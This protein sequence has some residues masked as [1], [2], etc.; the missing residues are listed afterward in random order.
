M[1]RDLR[2]LGSI[3]LGNLLIAF[4]VSAF[5]IPFSIMQGGTVGM[6]FTIKYLLPFDIRLS[7]V[8]MVINWTLFMVGFLFLGWKFSVASLASTILF[9]MMLRFF[10]DH[11]VSHLFVSEELTIVAVCCGL[12]IGCGI[13]MII[14]AGGSSGGIDIIA[15]ILSRKKGIPVGTSLMVFD[16]FII[17]MQVLIRG[18]EGILVSIVVIAVTSFSVNYF[19]ILGKK[20]VEILIISPE[21]EKI[22]KALLEVVDCGLTLLDVETGYLAL[23]QKAILSVVYASRYKEVRDLALKY[24]EKAFIVVN[25]VREVRGRGYTFSRYPEN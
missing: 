8:N 5:V 24:D 9:P 23:G 12:L 20:K 11:S 19:T 15:C 7:V 4:A 18:M 25:N 2:M 17:L 10:E 16:F 22:R 14:R 21:Y 3:F 13:G 6:S 1:K